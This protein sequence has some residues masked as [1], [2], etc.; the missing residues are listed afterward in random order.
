MTVNPDDRLPSSAA[1]A[2]AYDRGAERLLEAVSSAC[3]ARADFVER[4]ESGLRAALAL[5]ATDSALARLL[6][7]DIYAG[8]EEAAL[9]RQHWLERYG[10][11]LRAAAEDTPDT[12]AHPHFVEP[13]V[14]MGICWQI[15]RRVIDGQTEQ[16]EQLLPD[17]LEFTLVYYLDVG[18]A[19]RIAQARRPS[20][21]DSA[22]P[23][24]RI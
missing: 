21:S 18:D 19:I 1:G 11:L 20:P 5:L 16:L 8:G 3:D 13:A 4:V 12:L 14:M 7:G 6:T 10:A 22:L 2:A 24:H 15:S 23:R 17:L 9:R